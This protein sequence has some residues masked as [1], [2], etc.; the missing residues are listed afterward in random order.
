MSRLVDFKRLLFSSFQHHCKY[1]RVGAILRIDPYPF[2]GVIRSL[3]SLVNHRLSIQQ[4]LD[5]VSPVN[6]RRSIQQTNPHRIFR[7]K[8][9][10][11]TRDLVR[12]LAASGLT[13][14]IVDSLIL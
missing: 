12:L 8:S 14:D 7:Q 11:A 2:G 5:K 9:W 6:R 4:T 10:A 3:R 1:Q 13:R